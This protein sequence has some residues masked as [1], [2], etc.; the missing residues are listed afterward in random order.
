MDSTGAQSSP[1]G[2][3]IS[4]ILITK[5]R[6]ITNGFYLDTSNEQSGFSGHSTPPSTP[7]SHRSTPTF[8][9]SR[10]PSP[11]PPETLYARFGPDVAEQLAFHHNHMTRLAIQGQLVQAAIGQIR[12][13]ERRLQ[14][15][16]AE[17]DKQIAIILGMHHLHVNRKMNGMDKKENDED[18]R[19]GGGS[20]HSSTAV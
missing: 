15:A 18:G 19:D 16:K 13:E 4:K 8:S 6:I 20:G 12:S 17:V 1:G 3:Y 2:K 14:R 5:K 7:P 11:A 10:T 9:A